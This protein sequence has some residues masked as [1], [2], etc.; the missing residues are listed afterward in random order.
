MV[1]SEFELFS[2]PDSSP[3]WSGLSWTLS[4]YLVGLIYDSVLYLNCNIIRCVWCSAVMF[5]FGPLS[6]RRR[7][8]GNIFYFS[9]GSCCSRHFNRTEELKVYFTDTRCKVCLVLLFDLTKVRHTGRWRSSSCSSSLVWLFVSQ[10]LPTLRWW[11]WQCVAF[12]IVFTHVRSGLTAE[13]AEEDGD[14]EW[15]AD[16]E[17]AKQRSLAEQRL[18]RQRMER[19]QRSFR[20]ETGKVMKGL[21]VSVTWMS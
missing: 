5:S 16:Q 4:I 1:I 9:H 8:F 10:F 3:V 17:A 19:G 14:G 6:A 15:E 13:V 11:S 21:T 20:L 12:V 18:D 2:V 7:T